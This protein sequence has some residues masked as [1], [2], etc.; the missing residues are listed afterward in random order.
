MS[1]VTAS[2][3]GTL[4]LNARQPAQVSAALNLLGSAGASSA[5]WA[6]KMRHCT[7]LRAASL[8]SCTAV[9]DTVS[10][11]KPTDMASC[12]SSFRTPHFMV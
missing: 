9:D 5:F 11:L 3:L 1:A 6:P 4:S 2:P 8:H 7:G 12:A 10:E